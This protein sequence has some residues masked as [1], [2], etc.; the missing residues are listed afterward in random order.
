LFILLLGFLLQSIVVVASEFFEYQ[1]PTLE[2]YS[3]I[4]AVCLMFFCIKLLY[5]EDS[6]T[7]VEDHALL[8]NRWAGFFFYAGQ[9]ALLLSTTVMGSGLN[10]L[11]HSF[12]AATAALPGPEKT[13]VCG[14]FSATLLSTF[15]I[16]S[17]HLKRI[18]TD[19]RNQALFIAAYVIQSVVLLMVVGITAAMSF[20]EVGGYFEYLMQTDVQLLYC[21][22]G[23]ALFVVL[24][25]W[26]DE[27]VELALYETADDSRAF[28]LRP[29]GLWWFLNP[30]I[31]EAL[32][33]DEFLADDSETSAGQSLS[34]LS[35]LLG[36]SMADQVKADGE[37]ESMASRKQHEDDV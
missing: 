28:R 15:F 10:L 34:A 3:F 12:L 18:P 27:C 35:P 8:I 9:F 36:T 21:L 25:S 14:G 4:G 29:F 37:Y 19:W 31:N 13:L 6:D 16:K 17:M 5:V 11:T 7:L 30:E 2:E 24:M 33:T 22:S 1:T 23:A 26:L 20:G 32:L